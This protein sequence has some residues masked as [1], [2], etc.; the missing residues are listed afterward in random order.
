MLKI[1]PDDVEKCFYVD[2]DMIVDTD[3]SDIYDNIGNNLASVVVEA[4]AMNNKH[5]ILSH[6]FK[7][8]AFKNFQK[9]SSRHPYFNAGFMLLNIKKCKEYKLFEKALKF[10][11]ENPNPPYAD[12]DT[13]NAIIGQQY[14]KYINFL[15]PKYNVFCD[16]GINRVVWKKEAYY[17]VNEIKKALKNPKI[18]HYAGGH[19]PWLDYEQNYNEK[20]WEYCKMSPWKDFK[21]PPKPLKEIILKYYLFNVFDI[22]QISKKIMNNKTIF[23]IKIFKILPL[24]KIKIKRNKYSVMLFNIVPLISKK[25]IKCF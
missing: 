17:A 22:F 21:K 11:D 13:L 15:S 12:Q 10:L 8:E 16:L 1:L 18:F 14:T 25:R 7:S 4:F 23:K 6:C 19:K 9:D 5:E 24:V 3:L 2:G 20:W